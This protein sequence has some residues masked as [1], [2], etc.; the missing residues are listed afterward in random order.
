M[1]TRRFT[2]T[3]VRDYMMKQLHQAQ[4]PKSNA[5][6]RSI[7]LNYI[8]QNNDAI[9]LTKP[10]TLNASNIPEKNVST[11]LSLK[12]RDGRN[13]IPEK[14]QYDVYSKEISTLLNLPKLVE[15]EKNINDS[16]LQRKAE[17][18]LIHNKEVENDWVKGIIQDEDCFEDPEIKA[19]YNEML[20]CEEHDLEKHM[21]RLILTL[22]AKYK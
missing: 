18:Y 20:D 22:K 13:Y 1:A 21:D 19:L 11:I 10:T 15:M 17:R 12:Y 4:I 16:E 6:P 9:D 3:V 8:L 2:G 7:F 5:A 14:G